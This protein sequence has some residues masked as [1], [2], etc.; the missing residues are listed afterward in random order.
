MIREFVSG[1]I[2]IAK[3][4][5]DAGCRFFAGYPITPAS[6]VLEYMAREMPKVGGVF[7][8]AEDEIAAIN[9]VIG[10]S[11]AGVKAMTAT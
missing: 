9:M 3:G 4:A 7:V 10:A 5:L 8:Q 6:E 1:A 2:A 11:W